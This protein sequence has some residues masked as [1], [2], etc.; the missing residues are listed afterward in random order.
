MTR[1]NMLRRL[2]KG[3]DPLEIS[4]KKWKDI[5]KGKGRNYGQNNCAL[6]EADGRGKPHPCDLC[7]VMRDTG[8]DQCGATPY[9]DYCKASTTTKRKQ[10]ARQMR[11]FLEGLRT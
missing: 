6:C 11:L 8:T 3:D 7:V 4:I 1:E 9:S 5:E 2:K 10:Y